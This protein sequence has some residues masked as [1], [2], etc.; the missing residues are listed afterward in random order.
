MTAINVLCQG[1]RGLMLTDTSGY[2]KQGICRE[3]RSKAVTL[4]HAATVV[5]ARGAHMSTI[6]VYDCCHDCDGYNEM[7]ATISERLLKAFAWNTQQDRSYGLDVIALGWSEKE[8][9]VKSFF[10]C[11]ED[12]FLPHDCDCQL[13][14]LLSPEEVKSAGVNPAKFDHGE[15]DLL[16]IMDYQRRNNPG[17]IGGAAV[18]T[19]VTETTITQQVIHRWP[20]KRGEKI[21]SAQS[22]A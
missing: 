14:P 6:S 10:A 12:G 1:A 20:D 7:R 11:N 16:R 4:P 21:A 15:R 9:C 22:C 18:L 2:D 17:Q 19:I 13:A 8:R 3:W 5:A